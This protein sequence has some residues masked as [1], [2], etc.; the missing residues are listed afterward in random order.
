MLNRELHCTH[1]H[2][3]KEWGQL[4]H[5]TEY[6]INLQLNQKLEKKYL[7][8]DKKLNQLSEAKFKK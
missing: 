6:D 1:L 7:A 3:A 4:K 8:M 2:A 5:V